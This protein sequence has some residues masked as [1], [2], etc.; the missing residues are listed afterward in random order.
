MQE[1]ITPDIRAQLDEFMKAELPAKNTQNPIAGF[2]DNINTTLFHFGADDTQKINRLLD[3]MYNFYE[4][5]I[6][7]S[8]IWTT[9]KSGTFRLSTTSLF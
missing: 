1:L 7:R 9:Q 5:G 3:Y 6:R 4:L 8:P 2:M